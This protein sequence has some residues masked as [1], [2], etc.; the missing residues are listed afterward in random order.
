MSNVISFINV[1]G[2]VGKS[3]SCVNVAGQMA[4]QGHKV[5]LLDNDSQG[6]L[7]QIL[8]VSNEYSMYDLYSNSKVR[9]EDCIVKYN[10]NIDIIPNSIESAILERQL[11][12]KMTRESILLNKFSNFNKSKYDFILIDN[13][14]FLGLMTTN[15]MAMSNYY[16]EVIDNSPSALQGLSM[17]NILVEDMVDNALNT[18]I[19]LLGILRNRFERRT[20]FG[21]QFKEVCEEELNEKLFETIIYDSIRYK[22]ASAMGQT[23]QEYDK[24]HSKPYEILYNEI[25]NR[26]NI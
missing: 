22:E 20:V 12:N 17:V 26:I 8:N 11:H 19:K 24:K 4:Q 18:K 6:N 9:V 13:S 23:I 25:R 16:I 15:A 1:K 2:G 14:P 10:D 7:S 3:M 5:L 21:R